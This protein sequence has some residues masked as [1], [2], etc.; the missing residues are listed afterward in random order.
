M[1]PNP[2]PG[3]RGLFG[4]RRAPKTL[5]SV[6]RSSLR[7]LYTVQYVDD[8]VLFLDDYYWSRIKSVLC[9][10][11]SERC[12]LFSLLLRPARPARA[13]ACEGKLRGRSQARDLFHT[14]MQYNFLCAQV[15]G[16][17]D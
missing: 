16:V 3:R 13:W 12:L 5:E 17:N 11:V 15:V 8:V 2:S 10:C 4:V 7:V 1:S 9:V 14:G 6:F